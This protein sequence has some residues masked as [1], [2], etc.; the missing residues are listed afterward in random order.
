MYGAWAG[1]YPANLQIGVQ[2]GFESQRG[3][4]A[5]LVVWLTALVLQTSEAEFDPLA[6]YHFGSVTP[7]A[8][9][10]TFNRYVVGSIPTAPTNL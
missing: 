1:L 2:A 8:V 3:H 6:R 5:G 4:H 7:M 9:Y 10:S